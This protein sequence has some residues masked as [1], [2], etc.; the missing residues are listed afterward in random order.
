MRVKALLSEDSINNPLKI[1][2]ANRLRES[3]I[4]VITAL[5]GPIAT[6]PQDLSQNMAQAH[7]TK[8]RAEVR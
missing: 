2:V 3:T 5:I 4:N 7:Y 8:S 1:Q 6:K